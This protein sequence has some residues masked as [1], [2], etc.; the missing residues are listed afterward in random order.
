VESGHQRGRFAAGGSG[1]RPDG[2]LSSSED[3]VL[4]LN[5]REPLLRHSVWVWGAGAGPF[6]T[7]CE[8]LFF[9]NCILRRKRNV[10]GEELA[11]WV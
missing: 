4:R 10:G 8:C 11:G 5:S 1:V 3:V 9:D 2:P 6:D 7:F